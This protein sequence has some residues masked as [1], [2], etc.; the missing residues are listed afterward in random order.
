[1][2]TT[3]LRF[4]FSS[5]LLLG[6]IPDE[7]DTAGY[8]DPS[9]KECESAARTCFGPDLLMM[10]PTQRKVACGDCGYFCKWAG[11]ICE[12]A[13]YDRYFNDHD[14]C[15]FA[16]DWCMVAEEKSWDPISTR[17]VCGGCRDA[18]RITGVPVRLDIDLTSQPDLAAECE[19]V[20]L[21]TPR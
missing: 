12:D 14:A 21:A 7:G 17:G 13:E 8:S 10:E 19:T 9:A 18:C 4:L 6:C 15:T 3:S 16:Y 5:L 2:T 1:M 20:Y 11:E